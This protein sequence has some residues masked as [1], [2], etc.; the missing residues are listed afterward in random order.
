MLKILKSLIFTVQHSICDSFP[1]LALSLE[2]SCP[3]PVLKTFRVTPGETTTAVTWTAPLSTCSEAIRKTA[4]PQATSGQ[5]F[6]IG[7]HTVVYAYN[8]NNQFDQRCA[9][10]FEVRGRLFNVIGCQCRNNWRGYGKHMI[11]IIVILPLTCHQQLLLCYFH[12]VSPSTNII[13]YTA[14]MNTIII[15]SN[16]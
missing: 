1:S 16:I 13:M 7:R 12:N 4:L 15:T 3:L 11:T 8:I 6:A 10:M 14:I 9:V 2:C 5:L